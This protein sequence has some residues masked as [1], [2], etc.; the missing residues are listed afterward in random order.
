MAPIKPTIVHGSIKLLFGPGH[1]THNAG[2]CSALLAAAMVA[3][4]TDVMGVRMGYSGYVEIELCIPRFQVDYA[5]LSD[6]IDA[7]LRAALAAHRKAVG[8]GT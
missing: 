8:L 1:D 6:K 5:A 7:A 2:E 4:P 3:H